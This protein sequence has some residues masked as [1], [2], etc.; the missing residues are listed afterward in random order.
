MTFPGACGADVCILIL[1]KTN[2]SKCYH[3]LHL[4][5]SLPPEPMINRGV[6]ALGENI[7]GAKEVLI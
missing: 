1:L 2:I 7:L 3:S 4:N 5:C 6:L